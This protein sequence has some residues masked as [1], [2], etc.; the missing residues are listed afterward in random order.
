MDEYGPYKFGVTVCLQWI[1]VHSTFSLT[2]Y[3]K[4]DDCNFLVIRYNN[5]SI[6]P[7]PYQHPTHAMSQQFPSLILPTNLNFPVDIHIHQQLT[8]NHPHWKRPFMISDLASLHVATLTPVLSSDTIYPLF[9]NDRLK[10]KWH[11]SFIVF[12]YFFQIL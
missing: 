8:T 9:Q 5:P 10:E 2:L 11:I 4:L 7:I 12:Q 6:S 3:T 1:T